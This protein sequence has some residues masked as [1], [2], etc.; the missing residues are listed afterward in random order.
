VSR[1]RAAVVFA[2]LA[3]ATAAIPAGCAFDEICRE[4]QPGCAVDACENQ[5]RDGDETD[6]DC[7]GL[8]KPCVDGAA[9]AL[10]TDCADGLCVGDACCAP[11]CVLGTM[12]LGGP[13][14]DQASD[15]VARDDG[16]VV[17]V[18]EVQAGAD[19]GPGASQDHG[20]T[21]IFAT[22]VAANGTLAWAHRIGGV[23]EDYQPRL[24][25]HGDGRIWVAGSFQGDAMNAAGFALEGSG[26]NGDLFLLELERDG[27]P[28][29]ARAWS[30]HGDSV[31]V[32]ALVALPDGG[33]VLAGG[34]GTLDFG[35]AGL[36]RSPNGARDV[37]IARVDREAEPLWVRRVGGTDDEFF[38]GLALTPRGTVVLGFSYRGET[39]VG[40]AEL[41]VLPE[42]GAFAFA[43]AEL[44]PDPGEV[45]WARSYGIETFLT[46]IA[47]APDGSIFATGAFNDDADIGLGRLQA[48]GPSD[49]FV[50]RFSGGDGTPQWM[51]P[52]G[53]V[54]AGSRE[55][56]A[57]EDGGA[58]VSMEIAGPLSLEGGLEVATAVDSL[59]LVRLDP[60]GHAMWARDGG[61]IIVGRMSGVRAAPEGAIAFGGFYG[62]L[63]L[64]A[65]L[66]SR[67]ESDIFMARFAP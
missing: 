40:D 57:T 59:L 13:G 44:D 58:L 11:P 65:P 55:V 7:G 49:V 24:L 34:M 27:A 63:A 4:G 51:V 39:H 28:V 42:G 41:P 21:D 60:S 9:C 25:V 12:T 5:L 45:L 19:L 2:L 36:V 56:I 14:F 8:C 37:W 35:E 43:L 20:G 1:T 10:S 30:S 6:V 47:V 52:F 50:A 18:G 17:L 46:G 22:A 62:T 3:A 33:A 29:K 16:T 32:N 67:G 48:I 61:G 15:A 66:T 64:G 26:N 53:S 38:G 31:S 54:S 23:E